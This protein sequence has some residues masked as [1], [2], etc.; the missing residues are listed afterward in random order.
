MYLLN[1]IRTYMKREK[2]DVA[3]RDE[4]VVAH[5]TACAFTFT[6]TRKNEGE[7]DSY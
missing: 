4:T 2:K 6:V 7:N 3:Q 1:Y 5:R